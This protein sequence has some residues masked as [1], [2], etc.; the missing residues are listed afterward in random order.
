[1][2]L[3]HGKPDRGFWALGF[4]PDGVY[5]TA[6]ATDNAH[7]VY[8]YDWRQQRLDGPSGRGQM[9]DPPQV[10]GVRGGHGGGLCSDVE[11]LS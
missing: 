11:T 4:S 8:V 10:G 3:P 5:L 6:V 7:T 2:R 1:V 9:G